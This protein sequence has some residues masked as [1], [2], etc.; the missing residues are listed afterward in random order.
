LRSRSPFAGWASARVDR[1][2]SPVSAPR[3]LP[4]AL[5]SQHQNLES[6]PGISGSDLSC[7]RIRRRHL[8]PPLPLHLPRKR[9]LGPF[10]R[11]RAAVGRFRGPSDRIAWD[12]LQGETRVSRFDRTW[13]AR[14]FSASTPNPRDCSSSPGL[15]AA[16][17]RDNVCFDLFALLGA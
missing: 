15:L 1:A 7:R 17:T 12:Q 6:L 14:I 9:A 8:W 5:R 4:Q 13:S 11:W 10:F 16:P 2:L 3:P